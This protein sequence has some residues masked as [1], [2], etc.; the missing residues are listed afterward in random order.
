MLHCRRHLIERLQKKIDWFTI[1][2]EL[3]SGWRYNLIVIIYQPCGHQLAPDG[4]EE[5]AS[6]VS[7]ELM[8]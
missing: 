2:C 7:I 1:T 6:P 3:V 4:C 8:L 5:M